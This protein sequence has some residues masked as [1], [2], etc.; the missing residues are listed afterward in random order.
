MYLLDALRA[1]LLGNGEPAKV[2]VTAPADVVASARQRLFQLLQAQ[3]ASTTRRLHPIWTA[4]GALERFVNVAWREGLRGVAQD[5]VA[6]RRLVL[7]CLVRSVDDDAPQELSPLERLE[8]T[9]ITGQ[10][11]RA[12]SSV[13][14]GHHPRRVA[15]ELGLLRDRT[16]RVTRAGEVFLDLSG[17]DAV[18][19]LLHLSLLRSTGLEDPWRL[20]RD[21]ARM[22]ST[23]PVVSL[24]NEGWIPDVPVPADELID[25]LAELG[26]LGHARPKNNI[27][28]HI[29]TLGH[30]ALTEVLADPPTPMHHLARAVLLDDTR[31]VL[32]EL[33]TSEPSA[34][35]A[36][37]DYSRMVAHELRNALL[38]MRGALRAL[39]S[40]PLLDPE[41]RSTFTQRLQAGIDRLERFADEVSR[42]SQHGASTAR[43]AVAQVVEEAIAVTA[44]EAN[45]HLRVRRTHT[46]AHVQA[47]RT[48][49]VLAL[50]NL[51][52]NAAQVGP[53]LT[54]LEIVTEV[55]G[56]RVVITFTDNGPG[57]PAEHTSQIFEHGFSL[58][59]GSGIGL[60]IVREV[61]E[62]GLRGRVQYQ[63][64]PLGGAC[65]QLSIPR[66]G[67]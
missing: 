48:Q 40:R 56:D 50:S 46:D 64:G 13:D 35:T 15:V 42:V 28:W 30:Q 31:G 8:V 34:V 14:R 65:F 23:N 3:P 25:L 2:G 51:I 21:H 11:E 67:A 41:E 9:R 37:V 33:P 5:E 24:P 66:G 62:G 19:W 22:L 60:A 16:G 59:G 32:G 39:R 26:V 36:T 44:H 63:R 20:C 47:D 18:S 6:A 55:Q 1:E 57:V 17:I 27:D 7:V 10:A 45:G 52:R 38:P 61:I 54:E 4:D 12:R 58:R 29:S 43:L 53:S 49:L